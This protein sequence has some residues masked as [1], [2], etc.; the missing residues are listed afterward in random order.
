MNMDD[1][2]FRLTMVYGPTNTNVRANFYGELQQ[3]KPNANIPWMVA[4]DMNVTLHM[5]D[6]SNTQH[7][8]HDMRLFQ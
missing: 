6:R 1:T 2:I 3:A 4:G 8:P 5:M 7:T